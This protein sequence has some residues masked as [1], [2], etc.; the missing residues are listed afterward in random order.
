MSRIET[1]QTIAGIARHTRGCLIDVVVYHTA[2]TGGF[3]ARC[4]SSATIHADIA[5]SIEK[6]MMTG[7]LGTGCITGTVHTTLRTVHTVPIG[8]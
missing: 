7:T 2:H 5:G 8:T 4:A 1:D 3:I 6:H